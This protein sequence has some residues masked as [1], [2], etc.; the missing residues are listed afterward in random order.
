[1]IIYDLARRTYRVIKEEKKRRTGR[2]VSPVRRIERVYPLSDERVCAMTFD[3]G[4]CILPPSPDITGGGNSL[5]KHLADTLLS[6]GASATF[7]VV[8]DTSENYPDKRGKADS[9]YWGG[10]QYD[11]Y[12]DFEKDDFGGAKNCPGLIEYLLDRG[13]ELANHGYRHLLFGKSRVYSRRLPLKGP[14]AAI[15][16]LERLHLLIEEGYGVKLKLARPPHYIDFIE[17]GFTAYD[18]YELLG[19]NYMAASFDGAGWMSQKGTYEEDVK[20]MVEPMRRALETD[21]NALNGQI[22]FQKDGCNM[23]RFTPIASA[24]PI[25]LELL[26]EH[27]YRV[28]AVG[29]LMKMSPFEDLSEKDECF[30]AA[31]ELERQGFVVG[32]KNNMFYPDRVFTFGELCMALCPKEEREKRVRRRMAGEKSIGGFSLNHPYSAALAWAAGKGVFGG[33]NDPASGRDMEKLLDAS[34]Y[35]GKT[36]GIISYTRREAVC[37]LMRAVS[38]SV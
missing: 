22:I 17:R 33:I 20:R 34:G 5:T 6:F 35:G 37:E 16:D 11:H 30:D 25:Q 21:E 4:P 23:S 2:F 13:F 15:S 27:G 14:E 28:C 31:C 1:M 8:G 12:P 3:D 29:E 26:K 9:F 10:E 7:D 38:V 19:Y 18:I 32:C 24:L 36:A